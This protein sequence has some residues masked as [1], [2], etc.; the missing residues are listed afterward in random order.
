MNINA[1]MNIRFENKYTMVVVVK[2]K[3]VLYKKT[4]GLPVRYDSAAEN[5]CLEIASMT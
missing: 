4:K 1:L 5:E 3:S 2:I